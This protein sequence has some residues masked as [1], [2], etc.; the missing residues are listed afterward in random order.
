[1]EENKEKTTEELLKENN[2]LLKVLIGKLSIIRTAAWMFVIG[3]AISI[4]VYLI[5]VINS[6]NGAWNS[7]NNYTKQEDS[8]LVDSVLVVDSVAVGDTTDIDAY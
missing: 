5:V 4:L 8:E 3:V 2:E 6:C 1:M 7:Y